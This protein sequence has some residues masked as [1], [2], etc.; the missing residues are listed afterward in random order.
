MNRSLTGGMKLA[1][2]QLMEDGQ[3][4]DLRFGTVVSVSPLKIQ[5]TNLLTL[6]QSVLIVP[7]HLTN[8]KVSVTVDWETNQY[9][10]SHT[11]T[12]SEGEG[13]SVSNDTHKHKVNGTK[14][15]TINNALKV[16]D[17]VALIRKTGGQSYYILDRI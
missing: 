10:H 9:Q 4:C 14:T 7:E 5:I 17:K 3:M 16:N 12:D 13:C 11:V 2:K 15:I 6:P 1:A 8:H